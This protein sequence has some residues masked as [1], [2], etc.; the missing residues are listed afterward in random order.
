MNHVCPVCHSPDDWADFLTTSTGRVLLGDHRIVPG[1]IHKIQCRRCGLVSQHH[2]FTHAEAEKFYGD[3]YCLNL[4][5]AQE[6]VFFTQQGAVLRSQAWAEWVLEELPALKSGKIWE[7]GCGPGLLMSRLQNA[8]PNAALYGWDGNPRA[9]ALARENGLNVDRGLITTHVHGI[10]SFDAILAIGVLEL[11]PDLNIFLETVRESLAPGGRFLCSMPM[12]DAISYSAF[13]YEHHWLMT[14][15][16]LESVL[17]GAGF[18]ILSSNTQHPIHRPLGLFVAEKSDSPDKHEGIALSHTETTANKT[19]WLRVF[20]EL[21]RWLSLK[22]E[23]RVAVFGAGEVLALF[24]AYTKLG[25]A[26]PICC[27]DDDPAKA[28][29]K[30]FGIP[31]RSLEWLE[32]LRDMPVILCLNPKYHTDVANRLRAYTDVVFSWTPYDT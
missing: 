18:R 9:V 24:L 28:G 8:L 5:P 14:Q 7:I 15:A 32:T 13:F 2:P 3:E 6:H 10:G 26:L 20:G 16:Q 1:N 22:I 27:L 25:E 11:V 23:Q 31:V 17:A 29:S 19:R 30:V 21:D 12:Q 4:P